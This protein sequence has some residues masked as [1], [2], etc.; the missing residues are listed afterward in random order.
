MIAHI[1]MIVLL[2]GPYGRPIL[3]TQ[4]FSDK[5]ACEKALLWVQDNTGPKIGFSH[6]RATCIPK[7]GD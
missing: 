3:S 2:S 5:A 1:L 7:A 6:G 4:E